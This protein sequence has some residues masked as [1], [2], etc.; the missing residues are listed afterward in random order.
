MGR[1]KFERMLK[2]CLANKYAHLYSRSGSS[3]IEGDGSAGM[4]LMM[5]ITID[6]EEEWYEMDI[7][8]SSM[9]EY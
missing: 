4:S 6:D 5:D 2:L 1:A 3:G 9:L 7:D 8:G